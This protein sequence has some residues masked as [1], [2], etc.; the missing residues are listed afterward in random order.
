M[1]FSPHPEPK[2]QKND[3]KWGTSE[4]SNFRKKPFFWIFFL[5]VRYSSI[6]ALNQ[7]G[8]RAHH[9]ETS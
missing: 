1:V 6:E 8:M 9:G 3:L 5:L 7:E 2:K 4:A